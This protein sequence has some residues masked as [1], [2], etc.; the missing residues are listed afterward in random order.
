MTDHDPEQLR[1]KASEI[2]AD[3]GRTRDPDSHGM[4]TRMAASYLR[5]ARQLEEMARP[6][7][8]RWDFQQQPAR[9]AQAKDR[10]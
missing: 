6:R 4:L 10:G 9:Q 1:Q 7:S 5:M 8:G 3:A 2:L